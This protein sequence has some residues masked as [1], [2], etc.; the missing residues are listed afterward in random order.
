MNEED[1]QEHPETDKP[2]FA[3]DLVKR[4]VSDAKAHSGRGEA[5]AN[6]AIGIC[7][8]CGGPN[9]PPDSCKDWKILSL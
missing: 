2:Y 3:F 7:F 9:P 1:L 4:Q 6:F 8:E 5:R